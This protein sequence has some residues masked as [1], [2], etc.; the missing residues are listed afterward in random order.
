MNRIEE[1]LKQIKEKR[2]RRLLLHIRP[3]DYQI[4][5]GTKRLIKGKGGGRC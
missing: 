5:E 2:N 4:L 1:K 3:L